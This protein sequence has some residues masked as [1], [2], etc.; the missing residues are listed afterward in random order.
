MTYGMLV[1]L[2]ALVIALVLVAFAHLSARN[3]DRHLREEQDAKR[4]TERP[5]E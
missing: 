5:A 4:R 1:P 3:L 2:G